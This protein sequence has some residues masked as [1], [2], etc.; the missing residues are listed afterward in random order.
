MLHHSF[1]FVWFVWFVW[2]FYINPFHVDLIILLDA[3]ASLGGLG[4]HWSIHSDSFWALFRSPLSV[5]LSSGDLLQ[6]CAR[7]FYHIVMRVCPFPTSVCLTHVSPAAHVHCTSISVFAAIPLVQSLKIMYRLC[8]KML[9]WLLMHVLGW[10][11]T[12]CGMRTCGTNSDVPSSSE[13]E[14]QGPNAYIIELCIHYAPMLMFMMNALYHYWCHKSAVCR[15]WV[16]N[17]GQES[18]ITSTFF[19]VFRT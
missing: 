17:L 7:F 18:I 1:W 11:T 3:F 9:K 16:F 14:L 13:S 8:R 10:K 5:I 19:Y 12:P 4:D 15:V 6:P 2:V